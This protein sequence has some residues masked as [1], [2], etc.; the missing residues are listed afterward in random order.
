M[1]IS[2]SNVRR[3][4]LY[5][6][7]GIDQEGQWSRRWLPIEVSVVQDRAVTIECN[8]IAV[9]QFRVGVADCLAVSAVNHKL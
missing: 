7:P 5:A 3:I 9:G 2:A 8:N 4:A 1:R 6:R